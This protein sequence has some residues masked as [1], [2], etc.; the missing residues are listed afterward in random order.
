MV[1]HRYR[2]AKAPCKVDTK[3][4]EDMHVVVFEVAVKPELG[5]RYFDIAAELKPELEKIDGFISVERFE[6]LVTPNK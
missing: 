4:K 3:G 6:S 1:R 2:L 5:Q